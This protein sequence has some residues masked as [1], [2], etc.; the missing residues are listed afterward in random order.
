VQI[1]QLLDHGAVALALGNGSVVSL[2][3]GVGIVSQRVFSCLFEMN[4]NRR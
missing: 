4:I 1:V 2:G 3:G